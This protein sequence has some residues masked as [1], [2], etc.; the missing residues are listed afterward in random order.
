M[1][2][3]IDDRLQSRAEYKRCLEFSKKISY[4]SK[5]LISSVENVSARSGSGRGSA[6][7]WRNSHFIEPDFEYRDPSVDDIQLAATI[8]LTMQ[9]LILLED[10]GEYLKTVKNLIRTLSLLLGQ[11]GIVYSLQRHV[12][13]V[14][15]WM[16][17]SLANSAME[18]SNGCTRVRRILTDAPVNI[19]KAILPANICKF[20]I[21]LQESGENLVGFSFGICKREL[22]KLSL[23]GD[24]ESWGLCVNAAS[25]PNANISCSG[26]VSKSQVA[27]KV[28]DVFCLSV[29]IP[30]K[31][32]ELSINGEI[33]SKF[34]LPEGDPSSFYFGAT[35]PASSCIEVIPSCAAPPLS[36][37]QIAFHHLKFKSSNLIGGQIDIFVA[38]SKRLLQSHST[39]EE[40]ADIM[41]SFL[42]SVAVVRKNFEALMEVVNELCLGR[43]ILPACLPLLMGLGSVQHNQAEEDEPPVV[44]TKSKRFQAKTP[45]KKRHQSKKSI[46]STE[47]EVDAAVECEGD[48]VVG[49]EQ[50][51]YLVK[52]LSGLYLSTQFAPESIDQGL[53]DI[54]TLLDLIQRVEKGKYTSMTPEWTVSM[55]TS[56]LALLSRILHSLR[57]KHPNF[58]LSRMYQSAIVEAIEA[59]V[60][61]VQVDGSIASK[62]FECLSAH[63]RLIFREKSDFFSYFKNLLNPEN[64]TSKAFC[65][66]ELLSCLPKS[67]IIE[68]L[69]PPKSESMESVPQSAAIL[70]GLTLD[71]GTKLFEEHLAQL[72]SLSPQVP[73]VANVVRRHLTATR[74]IELQ[75]K[76]ALGL[77]YCKL[78]KVATVELKEEYFEAMDNILDLSLVLVQKS[79][80]CLEHVFGSLSKLQAIDKFRYYQ[81]G[82]FLSSS[83]IHSCLLN[84]LNFSKIC[85]CEF[86]MFVQSSKLLDLIKAS[87]VLERQL[88]RIMTD[89]LPLE[90]S[91]SCVITVYNT[92]SSSLAAFC[93]FGVNR[94]SLGAPLF[95]DGMENSMFIPRSESLSIRE[96]SLSQFLQSLLTSD[97]S[98]HCDVAKRLLATASL[99]NSD[100]ENSLVKISFLSAAF[101]SLIVFNSLESDEAARDVDIYLANP[102]NENLADS[103]QR[104][105]RSALSSVSPFCVNKELDVSKISGTD[106]FR[107]ALLLF[108]FNC[109]VDM[110]SDLS[111]RQKVLKFSKT[112]IFDFSL[113]FS[114]TE[115]Q[116]QNVVQSF[117][118]RTEILTL[119]SHLSTYP[120]ANQIVDTFDLVILSVINAIYRSQGESDVLLSLHTGLTGLSKEKQ[121]SLVSLGV[122]AAV[123]VAKRGIRL[124]ELLSSSPAEDNKDYFSAISCCALLGQSYS[125]DEISNPQFMH[126]VDFLSSCIMSED[127]ILKAYSLEVSKALLESCCLSLRNQVQGESQALKD[128]YCKI[129][130]TVFRVVGDS[131][132]LVNPFLCASSP[133]LLSPAS[134]VYAFE[135]PQS[136]R[137]SSKFSSSSQSLSFRPMKVDSNH[138][139]RFPM[140]SLRN[141]HSFSSWVYL[142]PG[143]D[144]GGLI[145]SKG[146]PR[147]AV[148]RFTIESVRAIHDGKTLYSSGENVLVWSEVKQ[149]WLKGTVQESK[150]FD[151][152][153][154]ILNGSVSTLNGVNWVNLRP[155]FSAGQAQPDSVSALFSIGG[156][157]EVDYNGDGNWLPGIVSSQLTEKE[158]FFEIEFSDSSLNKIAL[159]SRI[160]FGLT[161][162][163]N[164]E[165]IVDNDIKSVPFQFVSANTVPVGSW[166]HVAYCFD[167]SSKSAIFFLNGAEIGRKDLPVLMCNPNPPVVRTSR[168]IESAHNYADNSDIYW[169]ISIPNAEKVSIR[170]DNR[171]TTEARCDYIQFFRGINVRQDFFGEKYS[172]SKFPGA[173]GEPPLEI[174]NVTDFEIYFH[175]DASQ[176]A[177]GFKIDIVA[178]EFDPSVSAVAYELSDQSPVLLGKYIEDSVTLSNCYICGS[179]FHS[180]SLLPA[181]VRDL[182]IETATCMGYKPLDL[183]KAVGFAQP[184]TITKKKNPPPRLTVEDADESERDESAALEKFVIEKFSPDVGLQKIE[185]ESTVS[186]TKMKVVIAKEGEEF[187]RPKQSHPSR[188]AREDS[189]SPP[190]STMQK[191]KSRSKFASEGEGRL[192]DFEYGEERS[193]RS[194]SDLSPRSSVEYSGDGGHGEG[195]GFKF[196]SPSVSTKSLGNVFGQGV[197]STTNSRRPSK[198]FSVAEIDAMNKGLKDKAVQYLESQDNDENLDTVC[199]DSS[200]SSIVDFIM[201]SEY[202]VDL[203]IVITRAL[204]ILPSGMSFASSLSVL[205]TEDI[206]EHALRLASMSLSFSLQISASKF[207]EMCFKVLS[208]EP[209]YK[210]MLKVSY[211]GTE[212][213]T[214]GL[215][216]AGIRLLGSLNNP[217]VGEVSRRV[218]SERCRHNSEVL[219]CIMDGALACLGE[220]DVE[221]TFSLLLT[222]FSSALNSSIQAV[223]GQTSCSESNLAQ[224]IGFF[225]FCGSS[226]STSSNLKQRI[227]KW[228]LKTIKSHSNFLSSLHSLLTVSLPASTSCLALPF[229]STKV[230]ESI[231]P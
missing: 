78:P 194:S 171:S 90:R 71:V 219:M 198:E 204:S 9:S 46:L 95:L 151:D 29:N 100:F 101:I 10:T 176:N 212:A 130:E 80:R 55:W 45:H 225:V 84:G 1:Q 30:E 172:G 104:I 135:L 186:S 77:N 60:F 203:F 127:A 153:T 140:E 190:P 114:R 18:F 221:R 149:S 4:A 125:F 128:I 3:T 73:H 16:Q 96:E 87:L 174:I 61:S 217:A 58:S 27:I 138:G 205:F 35:L 94:I 13:S 26:T 105:L 159:W 5:F 2:R 134:E 42:F 34:D 164:M 79:S 150:N 93:E 121:S 20:A 137:L 97:P 102:T 119:L 167:L 57:E 227:S 193:R 17:G 132:N 124:L 12:P 98:H 123:N 111:R 122:T 214:F 213:E 229:N 207:L 180:S 158:L 75:S 86:K 210:R 216:G 126:L 147:T 69:D 70:T 11:S 59:S 220:V 62:A 197:S 21:Q 68:L 146:K 182:A 103:V 83:F 145:F 120:D 169:P 202:L 161:A 223:N 141:F 25:L 188:A 152:T 19:V 107:R 23:F 48:V 231:H 56:L 89:F 154:I 195:K 177:W 201:L 178:T 173:N 15:R 64:P 49:S 129:L 50:C 196:L 85:V 112:F 200:A 116:V 7:V 110:K 117:E 142:V 33:L 191:D 133:S 183:L 53:G 54:G 40:F 32:A 162:Q 51:L 208:F 170:F 157:V 88:S 211:L 228:P 226:L 47:G 168:S 224:C 38:L 31:W 72:T 99:L 156:K 113:P 184:P 222:E 230:I 160:R 52:S 131:V 108:R 36:Y 6:E 24:G 14:C 199:E 189:A 22:E 165:L 67:E 92:L 155:L 109:S 218:S 143:G 148:K 192:N 37:R 66:I 175:S 63:V 106:F 185:V 187:S 139:F 39:D 91:L 43:R 144:C 115:L 163:R 82:H 206:M 215:F 179:T 41:V 136:S 118:L 81:I 76:L 166:S 44:T 209:V 181:D 65:A 74:A 28:D 8:S